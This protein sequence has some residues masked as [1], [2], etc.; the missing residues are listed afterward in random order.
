M[1]DATSQ[2]QKL[3]LQRFGSAAITSPIHI[4]KDLAKHYIAS[5][6]TLFRAPIRVIDRVTDDIDRLL[7]P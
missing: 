7:Q 5:T 2:V 4:P 1:Q 3:R 6:M